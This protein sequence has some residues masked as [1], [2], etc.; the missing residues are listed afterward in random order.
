MTDCAQE[1]RRTVEQ[2]AS[3][4]APSTTHSPKLQIFTVEFLRP[5]FFLSLSAAGVGISTLCGVGPSTHLWPFSPPFLSSTA[6]YLLPGQ[7]I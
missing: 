3:T 2:E 5:M 1:T 7:F 6:E 4:H